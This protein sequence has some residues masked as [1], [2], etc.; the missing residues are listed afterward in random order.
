[1]STELS[2]T[3]H[4]STGITS[5]EQISTS[6]FSND[7]ALESSMRV[8]KALASS[9]IVPKEYQG[10]GN[11]GNTLI[12]LEM[13]NR[14]G[15]SPLAVMQ[16]IHIIHG[17]PGFSAQF[18]ISVVNSCG[19]F[20]PLRFEVSGQGDDTQCRAYATDLES[21]EVVKGPAVSIAMAKAEGWF[22]KSGSKWKTMPELM[23]HYRAA[24]FFARLYAPD[25][26]AGFMTSEELQDIRKRN[27]QDQA[28]EV[29]AV[30]KED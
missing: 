13:S 17:K 21:G 2:S 14:L 4:D 27:K 6:P 8:A 16:N 24:A 28:T 23:L 3:V 1:M 29:M 5:S 18:L 30:L 11:I 12:A 10:A 26:V 20:S 22:S 25:L 19:R 7:T 9:S 15:V